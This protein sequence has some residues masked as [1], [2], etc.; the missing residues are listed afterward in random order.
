MINCTAFSQANKTTGL[1][2]TYRSGSKMYGTCPASCALNPNPDQ[3][4]DK[5]DVDY[6]KSLLKAVPRKGYAFTYT[7][8]KPSAW[9]KHARAAG[10]NSTTINY[11]AD[12][13][14]QAKRTLK[15]NIPTV[16]AMPAGSVDKVSKVH[17]IKLVQCPAEYRDIG[18]NGCGGDQPLCARKNRDYAIVFHA[19]GAA[20]RKVGQSEKG[21]C[22][23]SG[24]NV[25][26]HWR[27]LSKQSQDISDGS[28]LV[29]FVEDLPRGTVLRHH[30]AG[31]I[32]L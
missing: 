1:A 20:K 29:E 28:K 11:S 3:S 4:S 7:H 27:R 13:I 26:L 9:V 17:G 30:V 18:C 14:T 21:G 19:H 15:K 5:V 31:D 12:T 6:L 23:A 8:F 22:Y 25:A 2:V 16:I 32:G 10:E 24:G